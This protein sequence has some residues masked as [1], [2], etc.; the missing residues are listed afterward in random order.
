[1]LESGARGGYD[2]AK[3]KNL[4]IILVAG[5]TLL[6]KKGFVLLPPRSVEERTLRLARSL[7][8]FRPQLG[9]IVRSTRKLA[10]ARCP[11]GDYQGV[12]PRRDG[13]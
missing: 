1:M 2:G 3:K 9:T 13:P 6:A 10:L 7:S 4:S 8:A 11:H 5:S 12:P